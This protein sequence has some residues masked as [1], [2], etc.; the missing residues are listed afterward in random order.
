MIEK[1]EHRKG[2]SIEEIVWAKASQGVSKPGWASLVCTN[3]K[4]QTFEQYVISENPAGLEDWKKVIKKYKT[5]RPKPWN[6]L[7]KV[8][9]LYKL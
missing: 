9:E 6:E 3:S 5:R 1:C 7:T 8:T 2:I 4:K